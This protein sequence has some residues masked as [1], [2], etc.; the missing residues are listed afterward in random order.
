MNGLTELA[1]SGPLLLAA[2][3]A[4]AA[5]AVSFASPCCIPLVPG[6]LAYLAGLAGTSTPTPSQ[7]PPSRTPASAAVDVSS[8]TGPGVDGELSLTKQAV[9]PGAGRARLVLASLLFVAGFTV[10]FTAAIMGVLGLSDLLLLNEQVLQRIG[11]VVTIAMGLVFLGVVPM[12]QRELRLHH[13]PRRGLWGAPVLG[14]VFGL[15]WTPCLGPTLT[16]VLALAA[17]TQVGPTTVR[18]L[19]LVL[20]YSLGLGLPFVFLALAAG[21]AIRTTSWL[22]RHTR[23]IQL[24]GGAMLVLV[25]VLLVT[26]LWGIFIAWLRV[27]IGG[28]TVPL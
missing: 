9:A 26:G 27:P 5:G 18:G 3:L 28:F 14:A 25:G 7:T 20:A 11:G 10:V 6:Y 12:M 17:G 4:L 15:G 21:W 23:A 24:A 13:R 1:I 19:I 2:V 22:R 16:G 8:G